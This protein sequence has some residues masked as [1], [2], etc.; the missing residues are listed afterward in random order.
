M[1][2]LLCL[3]HINGTSLNRKKKQSPIKQNKN[4][5]KKIEIGCITSK[6]INDFSQEIPA[7]IKTIL[8]RTTYGSTAIIISCNTKKSNN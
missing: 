7:L 4:T 6:I 5:Y 1:Q 2:R 8:N 3:N